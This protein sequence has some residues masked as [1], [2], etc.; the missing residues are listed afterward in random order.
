MVKRHSKSIDTT[1]KVCG[2]CKGTLAFLGRFNQ[3]GTL[4]KQ[5]EPSQ[6]SLFVKDNFGAVKQSLPPGDLPLLLLD[7]RMTFVACA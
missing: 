1:K 2:A 7:P 6:F 5:R 4:A 3:D